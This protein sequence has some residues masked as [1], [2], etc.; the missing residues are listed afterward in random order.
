M[1]LNATDRKKAAAYTDFASLV[2]ALK[3]ATTELR[4]LTKRPKE[5]ALLVEGHV[6]IIGA[7]AEKCR[8]DVT[9]DTGTYRV[10]IGRDGRLLVRECT[11]EMGQ[12]H[13]VAC[14]CTHVKAVMKVWRAPLER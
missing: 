14:N 8:A 9:G 12:F 3:E 4:R 5:D 7:N 6:R 13:P 2:V 1:R 10:N 11:C